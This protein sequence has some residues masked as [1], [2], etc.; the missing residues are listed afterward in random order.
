MSSKVLAKLLKCHGTYYLYDTNRNEVLRISEKQYDAIEHYLKGKDTFEDQIIIEQFQKNGYLSNK[1]V[2]KIEHS[3][4]DLLPFYLQGSMEAIVLQVTQQCNF[5]CEYCVY[6]GNY[7]DRI[8]SSKRM[9]K[10][11]AFKAIDFL[12][13]HSK[14]NERISIGFYGGEPLLEFKLV[15]DCMKYAKGRGEGKEVEFL[16]TTNGYLLNDKVVQFLSQYNVLI[17]VSLDGPQFIH[18]GHRKLAKNGEGT[19]AKI[20]ENLKN[21]RNNY[22]ELYDNIIFNAV[23]DTKNDYYELDKF[24]TQNELV[25]DSTTIISPI[26]TVNRK[27]KLQQGKEYFLDQEYERFKLM[28]Q[29]INGKREL[30]K[31]IDN[32]YVNI[33]NFSDL[34]QESDRLPDKFQHNGPC[35]VGSKK[36]FISTDGLFFPCEKCCESSESMNIGDINSGFQLEKIRML[37]NLGQLTKEKCKNCWAIRLCSICPGLLELNHGDITPESKE[38]ICKETLEAVEEQ[39]LDYCTLRDFGYNFQEETWVD[40]ISEVD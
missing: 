33:F 9:S 14:N 32:F 17:T 3:E 31:M 19:Y 35:I 5:R 34:M 36:L 28:F 16:I 6:S 37:L 40:D 15:E 4:N 22:P 26:S 39:L 25:K 12:F 20:I 29:L 21:I 11:I 8:H 27:E 18:D 30:S 1:H 23:V 7:F 13:T 10:D 38:K 24:F 2:N